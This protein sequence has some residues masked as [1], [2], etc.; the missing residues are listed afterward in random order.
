MF[1]SDWPVCTLAGSFEQVLSALLENLDALGVNEAARA[2]I[3]G[4]TAARFYRL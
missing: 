1:G 4:G 3:F 2:Q